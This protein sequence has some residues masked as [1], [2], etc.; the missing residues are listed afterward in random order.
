VPDTFF[1]EDIAVD[2]RQFRAVCHTP[3]VT[4]YLF[5]SEGRNR[6]DDG[7]HLRFGQAA[8]IDPSAVRAFFHLH[9]IFQV[10]D[11][12]VDDFLYL[13]G[14]LLVERIGKF[15]PFDLD[16]LGVHRL[17]IL[18]LDAVL[19]D[20]T[21]GV[22]IR[23]IGCG[24]SVGL[25]GHGRIFRQL[26]QIINFVQ[27]RRLNQGI[28][29]ILQRHQRLD[30]IIVQPLLHLRRGRFGR[31]LEPVVARAQRHV[32]QGRRYKDAGPDRK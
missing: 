2:F 19:P 29:V 7:R 26:L 31:S 22:G 20:R 17:V 32:G 28:S 30:R 14:I 15:V 1:D 5:D 4:D 24:F 3:L 27:S 9:I 12:G 8:R 10:A 21:L 25:A 16:V 13:R 18:V 23:V 6:I 11:Q